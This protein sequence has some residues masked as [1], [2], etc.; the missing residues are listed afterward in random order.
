[1]TEWNEQLREMREEYDSDPLR[2]S[3]LSSCPLEQFASWLTEASEKGVPDCNACS[4]ATVDE[5]SRPV[6]RAVLLKGMED[7]LF[8]FYTNYESR[9]AKQLLCAPWASMHFPWFSMQRQVV[10]TGKV[11]RFDESKSEE[12]FRSRPSLSK[13]GAWASKQS[14]PL[15][16]R[17]SL[18]TA[19]LEAREKFGEEPPKPPHWGG[20]ALDPQSIEFWQGGPHRLHD[21]FL[22]ER[23]AA[24]EWS[25]KRLNP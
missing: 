14:Q 6:A 13:L 18:E 15:D 25:M 16:S 2:K 3:D 4:L 5:S 17:E 22:F 12:Y 20:L 19:F 10:V 11:T 7:G 1:M 21:R 24:N 23:N 8:V 9:K